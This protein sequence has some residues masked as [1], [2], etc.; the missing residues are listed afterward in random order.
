MIRL[1]REYEVTTD[2]GSE[3]LFLRFEDAPTPA[4]TT[5][6]GVRIELDGAG[7]AW[8]TT[9]YAMDDMQ[10]LLFAMRVARAR[11]ESTKAF[12]EG[13]LRVRYWGRPGDV[14]LPTHDASPP[15]AP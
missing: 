3:S 6:R 1:E 14:H 15:E 12:E 7:E 10:A 5:E 9:I 8:S 2:A 13:R 11:L 4:E